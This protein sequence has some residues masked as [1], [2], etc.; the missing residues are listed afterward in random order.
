MNREGAADA[1]YAV[2]RAIPRGRVLSYGQVA[3]A[4]G[5]APRTVGW[6]LSSAPDGV[7]W[8]RVVGADGYLRI[9]R[10]APELKALQ[11]RLL[12]DEGVVL[13]DADFV[14]PECFVETP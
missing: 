11:R 7:P 3:A 5:L 13:D 1:V 4:L 8:H 10:R 14:A 9:A 2:V 6:V 12:E